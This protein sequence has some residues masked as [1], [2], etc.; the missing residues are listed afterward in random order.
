LPHGFANRQP[1]GS[2][3]FNKVRLSAVV[4][5]LL[6]GAAIF[7]GSGNFAIRAIGL[8]LCLVAVYRSRVSDVQMRPNTVKRPR[9]LLWVF[10]I[11]MLAI[12]AASYEYLYQ[13][14]LHGYHDVFPGYL[15][16]AVGLVCTLVWA[17]LVSTLM[18]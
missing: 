16:A 9:R 8:L 5:L 13:D 11:A 10:G 6:G 18:Q 12:A 7:F 2:V 14:A 4:L 1:A 17:Y 3:V 15:F